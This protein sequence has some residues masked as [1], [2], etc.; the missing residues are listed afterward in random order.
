MPDHGRGCECF[1]TISIDSLIVYEKKYSPQVCLDNGAYKIVNTKVLHYLDG[2]LF[3]ISKGWFLIYRSYK[4]FI[5][6]ELI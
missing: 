2:S 4:C 3:E 5:T 6:I 1:T